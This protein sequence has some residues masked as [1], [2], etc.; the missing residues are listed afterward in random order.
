MDAGRLL[1]QLGDAALTILAMSG[2]IFVSV[3]VLPA[4][5]ALM[6]AGDYARPGELE[7]IR[8]DLGLDRP[9][10]VQYVVWLDHVVRGDLGRSIRTQRS[11]AQIFRERV[12]A[13]LELALSALAL[14]VIVGLPLGVVA[15]TH[16]GSWE[17]RAVRIVAVLWNSTP[18]FFLGI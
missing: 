1:R 13:T 8:A 5:P 12:P 15:A 16:R 9:L 4:D 7:A 6:L 18:H 11:V 10:Y 17:D 14:G 3:R 2:V